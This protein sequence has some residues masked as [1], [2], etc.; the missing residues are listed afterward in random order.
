MIRKHHNPHDAHPGAGEITANL[1]DVLQSII[2][3][4]VKK[5]DT[6]ITWEESYLKKAID[7]I[8]GTSGQPEQRTVFMPSPPELVY[9]YSKQK[10]SIRQ[11]P[12]GEM[13][14]S[15]DYE[16]TQDWEL[17]KYQYE[18]YLET[19]PEYICSPPC[20]V[21]WEDYREVVAGVDFRINSN[22]AIGHDVV[23]PNVSKTRGPQRETN[24]WTQAR[25]IGLK[26][27][28]DNKWIPDW[29]KEELKKIVS[30]QFKNM[31]QII[32]T[33][34]LIFLRHKQHP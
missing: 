19:L 22:Y 3:E 30:A 20:G 27:I 13:P 2:D 33:F 25:N 15:L 8:T 26:S 16:T 10:N 5:G 1:N 7:F 14:H 17:A 28:D 9:I 18:Q 32:G 6:Y 11:K 34:E 31:A 29:P 24:P 21:L 12:E 23:I 4:R